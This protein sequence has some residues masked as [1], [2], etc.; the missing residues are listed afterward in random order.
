MVYKYEI[1]IYVKFFFIDWS[2][3]KGYQNIIS[4]FLF[5]KIVN[6]QITCSIVFELDPVTREIARTETD[7]TTYY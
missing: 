4:I 7:I 2:F 5:N 1:N 3:Q 6:N